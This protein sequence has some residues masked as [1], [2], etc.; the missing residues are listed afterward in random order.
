VGFKI[1]CKDLGFEVCVELGVKT[2]QSCD[3]EMFYVV[4]ADFAGKDHD[5]VLKHHFNILVSCRQ[6]IHDV[7]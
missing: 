1:V 3:E 2:I 5:A 4:Y 6:N 7:N